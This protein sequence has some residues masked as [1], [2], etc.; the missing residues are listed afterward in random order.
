MQMRKFDAFATVSPTWPN[1]KLRNVAAADRFSDFYLAK[2]M[3]PI[4][5]VDKPGFHQMLER[6]DPKYI[7]V[8]IMQVCF[9]GSHFFTSMRTLEKL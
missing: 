1:P 2:D 8:P 5:S 9:K 6:F 4:C 7:H 3:M